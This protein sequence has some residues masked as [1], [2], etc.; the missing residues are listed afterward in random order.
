[1]AGYMAVM[2]FS[3]SRW[4]VIQ[5]PRMKTGNLSM[6]GFGAFILNLRNLKSLLKDYPTPGASISTI[7][8]KAL[9]LVV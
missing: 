3:L 8:G 7:W 6:P 9:P 1:M 5:E 2:V 4:L